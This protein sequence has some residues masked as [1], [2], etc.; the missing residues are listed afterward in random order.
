MLFLGMVCK[1]VLGAGVYRIR[2]HGRHVLL[3]HDVLYVLTIRCNL[4][5]VLALLALGYTFYFSRD[6]MSVFMDG[7]LSFYG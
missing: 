5:S 4:C 6:P 7:V 1:Q 3:L 2:L